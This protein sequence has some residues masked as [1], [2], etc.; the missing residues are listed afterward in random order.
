MK[1]AKPWFVARGTLAMPTFPRLAREE[2]ST[3]PGGSRFAELRSD[4]VSAPVLGR[5]L[6]FDDEGVFH[7]ASTAPDFFGHRFGLTRLGV[8]K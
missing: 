4:E 2:K 5:P 3:V 6:P 7:K 1:L 8:R